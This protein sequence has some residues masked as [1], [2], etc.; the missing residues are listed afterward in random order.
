M[1]LKYS[2]WFV[3]WVIKNFWIV[4]GAV[5]FGIFEWT[6]IGISLFSVFQFEPEI[7]KLRQTGPIRG[8]AELNVVF[9][10]ILRFLS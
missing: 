4:Y 6:V 8:V 3:D 10:T 1:K 9:V 7:E 2:G 5:D